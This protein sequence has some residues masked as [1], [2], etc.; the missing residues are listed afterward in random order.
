MFSIISLE[1]LHIVIFFKEI[2][3]AFGHRDS[4]L[5]VRVLCLEALIYPLV[6]ETVAL[7]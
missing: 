6:Y 1:F 4:L 5:V 2:F 3:S 7:A